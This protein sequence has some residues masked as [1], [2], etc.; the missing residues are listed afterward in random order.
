MSYEKFALTSKTVL[1]ALLAFVVSVGSLIGVAINEDQAATITENWEAIV[2]AVGSLIAIYGRIVADSKITLKPDPTKMNSPF[3]TTAAVVLILVTVSGCAAFEEDVE[4]SP[5]GRLFEVEA[6]YAILKEEVATYVSQPFCEED[7]AS[8]ITCADPE[9]V[10]R[11]D[12]ADDRA[13]E[14]LEA[15]RPVVE[16]FDTTASEKNSALANAVASLGALRALLQEFV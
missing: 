7:T 3:L 5:E 16:A 14:A 8:S 11:L 2:T 13:E 6:N 9:I 12:E 4:V 15:A 1:G 10:I